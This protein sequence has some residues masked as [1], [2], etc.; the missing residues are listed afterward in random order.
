MVSFYIVN[1]GIFV[2]MM[3]LLQQEGEMKYVVFFVVLLSLSF[4]SVY[5]RAES[6]F[7][8]FGSF[9]VDQT[10]NRYLVTFELYNLENNFKKVLAVSM[11]DHL[12]D[13]E[14]DVTSVLYR[15]GNKE[16]FLRSEDSYTR[17]VKA[18]PVADVCDVWSP[19]IKF[20]IKTHSWKCSNL[21][22]IAKFLMWYQIDYGLKEA[23]EGRWTALS[24][25]IKKSVARF[26]K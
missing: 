12:D 7:N 13:A 10:S 18:T 3:L 4:G 24:I 21:N 16:I 15:N 26:I 1:G 5:V 11:E 9:A 23:K 19:K 22:F 8:G 20:R 25:R 6:L 14:G 2:V 17:F